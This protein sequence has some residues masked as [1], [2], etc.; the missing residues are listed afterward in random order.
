MAKK[1][2][3][4]FQ[5]IKTTNIGGDDPS[6]DNLFAKIKLSDKKE[7]ESKKEKPV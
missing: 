4:K 2:K 6:M 3:E 5:S 7:T 1:K